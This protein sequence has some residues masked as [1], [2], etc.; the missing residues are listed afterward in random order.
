MISRLSIRSCRAW[1][2]SGILL[3][4]IS[5]LLPSTSHAQ[6]KEDVSSITG[7]HRIASE[8]LRDVL[9]ESYEG[10]DIGLRAAYESNDEEGTSWILSL[11]GFADASTNFATAPN[12][13]LIVDGSSVQPLEITG[14]TRPLDGSVLEIRNLIFSRPI[15][16]QI[17]N[18]QSV[19]AVIGS[20]KVT[21]SSYS[22]RDMG[23]ILERVS[24]SSNRRTASSDSGSTGS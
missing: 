7:T 15:F 12:V 13:Q 4:A 16:E 24:A 2:Y 11:Y 1:M 23:T 20:A 10:N 19:E 5:L 18:A 9:I 8:A 3:L 17:A 6:L 14:K 21:L 22:R